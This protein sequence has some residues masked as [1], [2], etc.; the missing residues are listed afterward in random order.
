[1]KKSTNSPNMGFEGINTNHETHSFRE[2][3]SQLNE[4]LQTIIKHVKD[5]GTTLA[6]DVSHDILTR[7][8][9]I[10]NRMASLNT[11]ISNTAVDFF[12]N[13]VTKTREK[14]Q[15][16]AADLENTIKEHPLSSM[17]ISFG[18]GLVLARVLGSWQSSH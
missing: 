13:Q 14:T 4:D 17:M 16:Y 10:A 3:F 1:M 11:H 2:E 8:E 7:A 9:N 15:E 12:K 6:K 5:S 18:A